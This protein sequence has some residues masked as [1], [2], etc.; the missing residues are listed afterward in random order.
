MET[1]STPQVAAAAPATEAPIQ[2]EAGQ[3]AQDQSADTETTTAQSND[4]D[5]APTEATPATQADCSS[6]AA[7]G[8][9]LTPANPMSKSQQKKLKRKQQWED[10]RDDRKRKRKEKRL[11]KQAEKRAKKSE[12]GSET[13]S[14]PKQHT[15]VP[16][17]LI[18]DC[19]FENL[20][21]ENEL[22][23]LSSQV[24]RSYASNRAATNAT[25]IYISSWGGKMRT[26]Y[27][28]L[29]MSQHKR[30]NNTFF[31]EEDFQEAG[32]Q[33]S[34]AMRGAGGGELIDVLKVA[35]AAGP[36]DTNTYKQE[37]L[38]Y[39]TSDSPHTLT[40][41]EPYTSYV[42][43]GIVD[44]NREKGLCYRRA[45]ERGIRTAKLP[46]GEYMVMASRQVLTTN[47]VV[48]I[49][50]S[51][52]ETGD[53]GTAFSSV[54]PKRKGGQLKG[55]KSEQSGVSEKGEAEEVQEGD[56]AGEEEAEKE[57]GEDDEAEI[58]A[59][60]A[61]TPMTEPSADE[62]ATAAA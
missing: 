31:L 45:E 61:D 51:W 56:E 20:M 7:T 47:Q 46:I 37:D 60:T 54:I 30:W 25:R 49:M 38:V 35:Q 52:L 23:S 17:S 42:I 34:A 36:Q 22:I 50:L 55:D 59:E 5:G 43:G 29:L 53:W 16:V 15:L 33:A 27:E 57:R 1:D 8:S 19:D 13:T 14:K 21:T 2:V 3:L 6:G 26:R 4:D 18:F 48:E 58:G 9:A 41:L 10:T 28:T 11:V 62:T 24:T 39:L 12:E 44:K 40:H 32:R